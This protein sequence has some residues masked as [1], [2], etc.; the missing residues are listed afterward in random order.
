MQDPALYW[1]SY[2][3]DGSTQHVVLAKIA[4]RL[5]EV[6]ANSVVSERAFSEMNLIHSKMRNRLG[7]EK[8]N[9]QIFIYMN[10]RVLDKKG[11][12]FFGDPVD[13]MPEDQ[14]H[15]EKELLEILEED[16]D[17]EVIDDDADVHFQKDASVEL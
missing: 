7:T 4:V 8:A 15:L 1:K 3:V 2:V 9:K 11:G 14:V 5:F 17:E 6:I 12:I 13:K 16:D 10:Q